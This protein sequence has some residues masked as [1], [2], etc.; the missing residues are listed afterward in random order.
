MYILCKDIGITIEDIGI[1]IVSWKCKGLSMGSLSFE[2]WKT[3]FTEIGVSTVAELKGKMSS[4]YD[5]IK[6]KDD[7]FKVT[8]L[9][10]CV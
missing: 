6:N 7:S 10:C 2:E 8:S 4:L 3:G 9:G 1:L 5:E